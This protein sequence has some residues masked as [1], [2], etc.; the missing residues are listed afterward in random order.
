MRV[1]E[2]GKATLFILNRTRQLVP[3]MDLSGTGI[4]SIVALTFF[5]PSHPSG[6]QFFIVDGPPPG[7]EIVNLAFV[8]DFNGQP[9]SLIRE[10]QREGCLWR[11]IK[12][13]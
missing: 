2:A 13:V 9:K 1:N 5:N 6:G 11:E 3:T 10:V 12:D 8:T 7:G 4:R